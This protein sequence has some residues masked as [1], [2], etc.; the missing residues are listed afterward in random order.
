VVQGVVLLFFVLVIIGAI[1]RFRPT[2]TY[3]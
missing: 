1:R 2:P 3:A